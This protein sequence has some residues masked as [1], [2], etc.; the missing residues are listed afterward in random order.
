MKNLFKSKTLVLLVMAFC[1]FNILAGTTINLLTLNTWM[2]PIQGKMAYERAGLIGKNV[3]EYDLVFLQEAFRRNLRKKIKNNS[4]KNF[5]GLYAYQS[6]NVLGN[7]LYNL[8]KF[9]ITQKAFMPFVNCRSVQCA[10][11]KGVLYMQVKL[12]NGFIIDTFSTHLQAYQKDARIRAKQLKQA[13]KFIN[14]MNNGDLPVL[15]VGDFNIIASTSEYSSFSHLLNG[16][17]D[18]W[19]DYRPSDNGFTWNPDIN[20]WA[21]YD[22]DESIQYQ[23]IDYIFVKDGKQ[24]KW[25]IIDINVMFN[26][27][28]TTQSGP[29]FVSDHFGLS[30]RLELTKSSSTER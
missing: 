12:A 20:T 9:T 6:G 26:H 29:M 8:S 10:A 27:S 21:N 28:Y 24:L 30:S 11:S 14:K 2:I 3:S 15:L 7:G 16:F 23:R 22:E 17:K 1:S 13:I 5:T 18:A 25:N 19:L 4:S